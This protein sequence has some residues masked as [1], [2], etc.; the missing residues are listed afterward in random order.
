[1]HSLPSLPLTPPKFIPPF[2]SSSQLLVFTFLKN[3]IHKVQFVLPRYTRVY[4]DH[5][6]K[7][8]SRRGHTLKTASPWPRSH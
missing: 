6:L 5:P 3:I 7:P 2:F 4:W 8:G 1:M